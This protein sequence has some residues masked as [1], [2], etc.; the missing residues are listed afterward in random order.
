[1]IEIFGQTLKFRAKVG[2]SRASF[3]RNR[4]KTGTLQ[5]VG[6]QHLVKYR[7][8]MGTVGHG[9][10]RVRAQEKVSFSHKK[11]PKRFP[12]SETHAEKNVLR[13]KLI[14]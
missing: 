8:V 12:A 3:G 6:F 2:Q 9:F 10:A 13:L 14:L 4:Q 5:I 1:M 11:G 7:A